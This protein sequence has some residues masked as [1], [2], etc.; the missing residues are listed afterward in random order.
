MNKLSEQ[1]TT[2]MASMA[3][4]PAIHRLEQKKSLH[5]LGTPGMTLE[6]LRNEYQMPG[7][8]PGQ[9]VRLIENQQGELVGLAEVWDETD[10]PVHPYIWVSIDPDYEEQGLALN[11]LEWAEM[12]ACQ[13]LDRVSPEMQVAMR[14]HVN[15]VVAS[16]GEALLRAGFNQIRH[17]FRMR[18]EMEGPP[19]QPVWPN[20]IHLRPYRPD[21][22]ARLVFE[23]DEEVFEDHFG[24]IRQDPEEG[25]KKYMH[26]MAGDDSYD[27]ALWFLAVEG[28]ELV[29]ICICR[30]YGPEEKDTGYISSLGVRRAWR[31]QGI[32]QALLLHAFGEFYNRGT[33]KVDL[34]VDA[35]SL[36]GAT[37]LYKKV[38]MSVIRQFDMYEKVLRPG[39]D[40]SV[41]TLTPEA[42]E[43][44]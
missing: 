12:R 16:A 14:S 20:G 32:A 10:P 39:R 13:A 19:P 43:V 3:D 38:G 6:R 23:T 1:F 42:E 30:R 31:R 26:H 18:I 29:A 4:L 22:D 40:I 7:F 17:S 2:R 5:Y 27:P 44:N 35:E 33:Y 11:L 25:F 21:V 8:D 34:G 41:N 37:E 15:H 24:Y 9:S 36:T 28:Q